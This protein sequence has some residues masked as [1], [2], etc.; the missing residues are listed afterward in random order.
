MKLNQMILFAVVTEA[1]NGCLYGIFY[2]GF[3]FVEI[4]FEM[5]WGDP[6]DAEHLCAVNNIEFI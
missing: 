4:N 2:C 6:P 3:L 5:D 1:A